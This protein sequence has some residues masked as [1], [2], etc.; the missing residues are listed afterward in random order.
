MDSCRFLKTGYYNK[1]GLI[2]D[3]FDDD[4]DDDDDGRYKEVEEC[5]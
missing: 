2:R 4:D 5:K 3:D 1:S